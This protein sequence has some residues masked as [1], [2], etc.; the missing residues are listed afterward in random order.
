MPPARAAHTD[1]SP[2][3]AVPVTVNG[4]A[5]SI[6]QPC[7]VTELLGLLEVGKKRVAVAVNGEVVPRSTHATATLC[8]G[9]Q[10]EVLEAVGGG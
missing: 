6:P 10:I 5:R 2:R 7:T 9:D 3:D 8:V 1:A 4:E